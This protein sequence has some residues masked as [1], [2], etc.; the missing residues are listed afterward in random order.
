MVSKGLKWLKIALW[1]VM[2]PPLTPPPPGLANVKLF[3]KASQRK[4]RII[5]N[6]DPC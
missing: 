4:E 1:L 5:M 2:K 3:F 6:Y